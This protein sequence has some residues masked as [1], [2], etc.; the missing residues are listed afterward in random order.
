MLSGPMN[1]YWLLCILVM[2]GCVRSPETPRLD[3]C[4]VS[5]SLDLQLVLAESTVV[6]KP[7]GD[8]L[9][10]LRGTRIA[11]ARRQQRAEQLRSLVGMTPGQHPE[12][13]TAYYTHLSNIVE[14]TRARRIQLD[15]E[16]A[17]MEAMKSSAKVKLQEKRVRELED[18]AIQS[19]DNYQRAR[20]FC[21]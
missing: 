4:T 16:I 11:V 7:S 6:P 21:P 20:K 17:A 14:F 1:R 10:D 9:D 15:I 3:P 5:K 12:I 18:R 2:G 13:K 19:R 8:R